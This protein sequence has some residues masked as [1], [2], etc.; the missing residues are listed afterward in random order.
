LEMEMFGSFKTSFKEN[1]SNSS[2]WPLPNILGARPRI[3]T[4]H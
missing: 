3:A 4:A 1:D 2:A